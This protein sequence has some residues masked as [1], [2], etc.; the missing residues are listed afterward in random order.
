MVHHLCFFND[1]FYHPKNIKFIFWSHSINLVWLM[2]KISG[3]PHAIYM[4]LREKDIWNV[5]LSTIFMWTNGI[6]ASLT[7]NVVQLD[8]NSYV[9]F[10]RFRRR[11]IKCTSHIGCFFFLR[12]LQLFVFH[13]T[14]SPFFF[15]CKHYRQTSLTAVLKSCLLQHITNDTTV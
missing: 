2:D 14:T 1:L 6:L 13:Y 8:S 11:G 4:K 15:L 9:K 3:Y 10:Q 12:H 5:V 7:S